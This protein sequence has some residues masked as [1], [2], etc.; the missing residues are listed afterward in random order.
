MDFPGD[1]LLPLPDSDLEGTTGQR[2]LYS[3]CVGFS[4]SLFPSL[5]ADDESRLLEPESLPFWSEH[6]DRAGLDGC[7]AAV[8]VGS[9]ERSFLGRWSLKGSA[10]IYVWTAVQIVENLQRLG[11]RLAREAYGGERII[12]ARSRSSPP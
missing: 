2:A 10:D 7:L 3:D 11:A 5:A 12:T 1:F 6:S 4:R 9:E 8:R